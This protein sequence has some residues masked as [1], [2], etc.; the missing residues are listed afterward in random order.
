MKKK[1]SE[2][3]SL[4]LIEHPKTKATERTVSMEDGWKGDWMAPLN[5]N[6]GRCQEKAVSRPVFPDKQRGYV[7]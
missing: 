4:T 6:N 2:G 5:G 3:K 1:E 7:R